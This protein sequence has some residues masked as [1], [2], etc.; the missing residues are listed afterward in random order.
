MSQLD[1]APPTPAPFGSVTAT[2]MVLSRTS[3][4]VFAPPTVEPLGP[5]S[6]HP[7]AHALHYGSSCFEGLKAHRGADQIVRLFRLPAHVARMRASAETLCLPVP[8]AELLAGMIRAAV[9]ANLDETPALPGALY[10][11]PV[12]LGTDPNVGAA[13]T[14][15]H[16]ALAYVVASPVGE[17]FDSTRTLTIEIE[18]ELPRSTPQFGGVKTGANYAMALGITLGAKTRGADQVLFAPDGDVQ[19][20]GASNFMLLDDQRLITKP[21][22]GSFLAGITRDS[23]LT[24]AKTL[25]YQVEERDL[26]VDDVL[27]WPGEAALTGTAAVLAG[28]GAFLYRGESIPVNGARPGHNTARLRDAL[29]DLQRGQASDPWGWTEP[30]QA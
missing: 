6:L 8:P 4:G 5:L 21:L 18:T 2:M 25:G 29:V 20:T 13:A 17:Y 24:L 26:S 16:E 11:R 22:D 7:A 1:I 30:I 9:R 15:S 28:V 12:L 10:V 23:I 27:A 3:G 19:E 14:P